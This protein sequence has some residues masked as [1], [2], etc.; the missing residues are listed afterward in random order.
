MDELDMQLLRLKCLE[1]AVQAD[2]GCDDAIDVASE[3]EDFIIAGVT[4]DELDEFLDD[5]DFDYNP[6]F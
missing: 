6:G 1:L 4:P 5:E 3:F 2:A